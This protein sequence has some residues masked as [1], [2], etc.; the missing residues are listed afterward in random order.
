MREKFKET[1]LREVKLPEDVRDWWSYN[2]NVITKAGKNVLIVTTGKG[3]PE[4][5]EA[6]WWNEEVQKV[7]KVKKDAKRQWDLTGRQEDR[8]DY[9]SARKMAKRAVAKAKAEAMEE[10]YEELERRQD[11]RQLLR[12]AKARDNTNDI[13][14]MRQLKDDLEKIL[15]KWREYF[16]RLLNEENIRENWYAARGRVGSSWSPEFVAVMVR[17]AL[18][19]WLGESTLK[20]QFG[21]AAQSWEMLV[22]NRRAVAA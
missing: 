13:T 22:S 18:A 12:T 2:S 16:E 17:W 15:N 7:I 14:S 21:G 19:T 20:Y 8:K 3:P 6:W 1:V 4:N 5:K 10:V 11:G 9:R